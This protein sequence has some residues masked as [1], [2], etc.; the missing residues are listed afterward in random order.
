ME[1]EEVARCFALPAVEISSCKK[2]SL[3][4]SNPE[5]E[6]RWHIFQA[7]LPYYG[8]KV[9]PAFLR[10]T[11]PFIPGIER[12]HPL[13]EGIY[14]PAWS[15]YALSIASMRVNPYKDKVTYLPD[16]RW[17]IKYS[18]KTGGPDIAVNRALLKCLADKEPVIVLEQL[19]D[20]SSRQ[21]T[22]YRLMGLGLLDHYDPASELF[23][24]FHVDYA[25]LEQVSRGVEDDVFI[26][27]ALRS[28]ALDEF[29][30][31]VAEDR[32]IY[33][34]APQKRDQAFASVILEQYAF[35]CAVTGVKY[36]AVNLTEAQ[37]AHIIAKGHQG[38]DDP[39]N[40][41]ALS[42]TAHWAF[43]VGM[44]TISD[45][46]EVMVHPKARHADT[47]K[48]PILD[49]H[50]QKIHLPEDENYY[51]HAEALAWHQQEVFDRFAT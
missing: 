13:I 25:T 16:G 19:S 27:S 24:I 20:R 15:D 18:A 21:G 29:T 4:M 37:A 7:L 1:E 33:Q 35:Q 22:Q 32:S 50:G 43:D 3:S 26:A 11:S 31:F 5:K 6:R 48:F 34:I 2:D 8:K 49:L 38:S 12:I 47:S 39:R 42:R 23:T 28:F 46:Y 9:R 41:I 51:P 40:G 10:Q 14:K 17:T 30:P 44:F 45:Q 36:H